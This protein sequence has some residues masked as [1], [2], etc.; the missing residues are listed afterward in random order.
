MNFFDSFLPLGI[1]DHNLEFSPRP[2]Y[3]PSGINA[4]TITSNLS[5]NLNVLDDLMNKQ[6]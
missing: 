6:K 1:T 2:P 3:K 5:N 4:S